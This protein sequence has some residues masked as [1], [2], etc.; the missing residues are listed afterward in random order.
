MGKEANMLLTVRAE[1]IRPHKVNIIL[2]SHPR[3]NGILPAAYE[4]VGL[5]GVS[6][7]PAMILWDGT[8]LLSL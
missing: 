5:W 2:V 7:I 8:I 3:P 1:L 6:I 4:W